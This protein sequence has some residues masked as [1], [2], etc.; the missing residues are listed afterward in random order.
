MRPRVPAFAMWVAT[1]AGFSRR[2]YRNSQMKASRSVTGDSERLRCGTCT[3]EIPIR[4]ASSAS[5]PSRPSGS[6][7]SNEP[8]NSGPHLAVRMLTWRAGPPMFK[9]VMRRA[10]LGGPVVFKGPS[11]PFFEADPGPVA[12][13]FRRQRDVGPGVPDV[14]RPRRAERNLERAAVERRNRVGQLAKRVALTG[15]DVHC[16]ARHVAPQGA[17]IGLD[18]VVDIG[19]VAAL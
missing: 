19:E 5:E 15:G 4:A 13:R 12:D 8:A 17:E 7:A 16:E 6:P 3:T 9:R 10:S 14:P 11:E 1:M 2:K 18:H